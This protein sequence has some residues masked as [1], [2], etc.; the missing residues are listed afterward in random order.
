VISFAATS[1]P[2]LDVRLSSW[3]K[4]DCY[5]VDFGAKIG[6]PEVIRRPHFLEGARE[7][8]AYFLPKTRNGEIVVGLCLR[9]EDM[10]RFKADIEIVEYG[11]YIG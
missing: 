4:E 5:D 10:K 6:K 2:E 11:K 3:A 9:D 1:T 7:G 8:L